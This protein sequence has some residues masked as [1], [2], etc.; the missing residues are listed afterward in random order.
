MSTS[1]QG[2]PFQL[3][4][5][6]EA[7]SSSQA[8]LSGSSPSTRRRSPM[9]SAI[10]SKA[11]VPSGS[12]MTHLGSELYDAIVQAADPRH[13]DHA[14]W[15]ER[16]GSLSNRSSRTSVVAKPST[17]S[18]ATPSSRVSF[19]QSDLAFRR[20]HAPRN[21]GYWDLAY[22]QAHEAGGSDA[23]DPLHTEERYTPVRASFESSSR[24]LR[25]PSIA[26][27]GHRR[28]NRR[29]RD[30]P[31][32]LVPPIPP[33]RITSST[34]FQSSYGSPSLPELANSTPRTPCFPTSSGNTSD[35]QDRF[36]L[37]AAP[38]SDFASPSASPPLRMAH[39]YASPMILHTQQQ[40]QQDLHSFSLAHKFNQ[41]ASFSGNDRLPLHS[42]TSASSHPK[43]VP[44]SQD[45][46]ISHLPRQ[47]HTFPAVSS[48]SSPN[49]RSMQISD[50]PYGPNR[51]VAASKSLSKIR[52]LLGPETP[53]PD[54]P[55]PPSRTDI[56]LRRETEARSPPS[57]PVLAPAVPP[58]DP[59]RSHQRAA[60]SISRKPVPQLDHGAE[61]VETAGRQSNDASRHVDLTIFPMR[62]DDEF[63]ANEFESPDELEAEEQSCAMQHPLS[64]FTYTNM[65]SPFATR[66]DRSPGVVRR[67]LDSIISPFRAGLLNSV[68]SSTG[69]IS[70]SASTS[71]LAV[72]EQ[73]PIVEGPPQ[74][75][76]I[77]T[78]E[79][80]PPS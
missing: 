30:A 40:Q 12:K 51:T 24:S 75:L 77:A 31:K 42:S 38:Q 32:P 76:R 28:R 10:L 56:P 72:P 8:A 18:P 46:G 21:A 2:H 78:R 7:D 43:R 57:P 27:S 80:F 73:E 54:S 79:A 64:S 52:Q 58:K 71:S 37:Q 39:P 66:P 48:V 16:Y 5:Y 9:P 17:S 15:Q 3:Q 14:A 41:S 19:E 35:N 61:E 22:R 67:S 20:K 44:V 34:N 49:E 45:A 59:K 63:C 23:D 47:P 4:S 68:S 11:S 53:I 26:S 6:T 69:R 13:P 33:P 74:L 60:G 50:S 62:R 29:L 65:P 1:L 55:S 25:S 70:A 36:Q